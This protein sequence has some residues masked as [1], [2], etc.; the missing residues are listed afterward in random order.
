M[1]EGNNCLEVT[2]HA[3]SMSLLRCALPSAAEGILSVCA[4]FASDLAV[5]PDSIWPSMPTTT[6][7]IA[8]LLVQNILK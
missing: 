7:I 4:Q 3:R 6:S 8:G 1:A 5:A 2:S